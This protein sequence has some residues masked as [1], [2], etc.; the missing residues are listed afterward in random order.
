MGDVISITDTNDT[1]LVQYEYDPWGKCIVAFPMQDDDSVTKLADLNPIRYRGYYL[2]SETGY[3]YLQSRYYDP[4]ICRFINADVYKYA[5]RL[6]DDSTG[7]NLFAYCC[8]NPINNFDAKGHWKY[9]WSSIM[10]SINRLIEAM[11]NCGK[12]L[13]KEYRV[14]TKQY[15]KITKYKDPTKIQK[16]VNENKNSIRYYSNRFSSIA[17]FM[18]ILLVLGEVSNQISKSRNT[19]GKIAS[20]IF[21][22]VIKLVTYISAKVIELFLTFVL[23]VNAVVK[24]VINTLVD[25]ILDY[26]S[27][28]KKIEKLET[29]YIRYAENNKFNFTGYLKYFFKA[30]GDV[31]FG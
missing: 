22:G 18:S 20:V 28:S 17:K 12:A 26:A 9:S 19:A 3:Y 23:K 6:K 14:S 29:V 11:G 10:N 2:D 25:W 1:E 7:L 13:I 15:K 27:N 31:V 21:Y 8:N 4:D 16:F 24:F 30:C 5:Q